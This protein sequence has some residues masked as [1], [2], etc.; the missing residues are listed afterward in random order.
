MKKIIAVI[1]TLLILAAACISIWYFL[2]YQKDNPNTGQE[3]G[4]AVYV[5]SVGVITGSIGLGLTDRFSGV[6]EPQETKEI[7]LE[8]GKKVKELL[9]EEGDLVKK[10][11]PLF[12]YD[13]E[14]MAL[15]IQQGQLE[16]ERLN[17]AIAS[18]HSQIA[19][20]DKE[21]AK[22]K[23]EDQL[24]YTIQ[25]QSLQNDIRR[26]EYSIDAKNLELGQIQKSIDNAAVN[27]EMAGMVKTINESGMT[28]DQW[29]NPAEAPYITILAV[30]NYRIKGTVNEMN[31]YSISVG[32]PVVVTSR[33]DESKKWMGMISKVDSEPQEDSGNGI[34]YNGEKAEGSTSKYA[35]YVELA[36]DTDT[37]DK[38]MLGQHV[39]IEPDF[40]QTEV[41]EGL[42]LPQW[43]VL[44][45]EDGTYYVW[46]ADSKDKL[47]K[48][49]IEVGELD[50]NLMEYQI[51]S[52]LS[53]EDYLAY[54]GE[55]TEGMPVIRNEGVMR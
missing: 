52:G 50:E 12:V 47:E 5:E 32:Q 40:G 28:I 20:L 37:E 7:K 11:T 42:W 45:E 6:V 43:F 35:F 9:V 29:G 31:L 38:L 17:N 4:E 27:S 51:I 36:E 48:R 55:Y 39:L 15:D 54:P 16:V 26:D 19:E 22:A 10:G 46:A 33:A 49:S 53:G 44:T 8:N 24:G 34:F 13:T 1:A 2:F 41:K 14:E 3:N 18:A 30:G 23:P 21:R 25:I